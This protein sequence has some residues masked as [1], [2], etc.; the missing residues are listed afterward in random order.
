VHPP[1]RRITQR[2]CG[3]PHVT[4]RQLGTRRVDHG[5]PR[6]LGSKPVEVCYSVRSPWTA[7]TSGT[8]RPDRPR[9]NVVTSQPR[10]GAS[11]TMLCPGT[12]Y[13]P[14]PESS[15]PESCPSRGPMRR[16]PNPA[17]GN[18]A[19]LPTLADSMCLAV[20][21]AH[22][23]P[24]VRVGDLVSSPVPWTY[25]PGASSCTTPPASTSH[26]FP[27]SEEGSMRWR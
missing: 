20:G 17:V 24:T 6:T 8:S 19:L 14:R 2:L 12:T 27:D 22:A 26:H 3:Q 5:I 4:R 23:P 13:H 16:D 9:L 15:C 10:R 7:R 18:R 25:P 21:H 11:P 1:G